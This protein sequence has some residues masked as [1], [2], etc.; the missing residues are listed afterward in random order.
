MLNC[1]YI[2]KEEIKYSQNWPE[3]LDYPYRMLIVRGSGSRKTNTLLNLINHKSDI[4]KIYFYTKDP[5]EAKH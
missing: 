1:D 5:Y 4:D 2:T 3:I